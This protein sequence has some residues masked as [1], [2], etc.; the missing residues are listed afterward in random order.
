MFVCFAALAEVI[1]AHAQTPHAAGEALLSR[2][3]FSFERNAGQF[4]QG[5]VDWVAHRNGYHILLGASSATI[6]PAGVKMQFT[7][8]RAAAKS[9]AQE[10]LPGKVNYLIGNDP[11]RWIKDVETC[12]RVVYRDVYD[13]VDVAWYGSEG[14]I[15]YD[16][17]VRPGA[18]TSRIALHFEGARKLSLAANGDLRIDTGKDPLTLR[19]PTVYQETAGGRARVES[20]YVLRDDHTVAFAFALAP[21]DKSRPLVIDP[22]LMYAA[23]FPSQNVTVTSVATDPQGNI[24][25]G[26]SSDWL[27]TVSAFQPGSMGYEDPFV[28]KFDPTG[29]TVLY[30]TFVGGTGGD[31]L[32]GLAVDSGGYA[33]GVGLAYSKDFPTLNAAVPTFPSQTLSCGFAF[34]LNGDGDGLTYSTYIT[35]TTAYAVA[36]DSSSSAYVALYSGVQKYTTNGTIQYDSST[37]GGSAITVDAQGSAYVAGA[38]HLPA[39]QGVPGAREITGSQCEA[40]F[41]VY[42]TCTY[43]AKLSADGTSLNWAAILGG[44]LTQAPHAIARDPNSGEIYVAGETTATDLPVTGGVIQPTLHGQT[45]G[46]LASV[47]PDGSAF[48][49]VTYLGGAANDEIYALSLTPSGQIVVAGDTFS[50]DFPVIGAAQQSIGGNGTALYATTDSGSDWTTGGMNLP[51]DIT[52]LS[53]DPTNPS[54]VVAASSGVITDLA[55]LVNASGIYRSTDS[56]IMWTQVA[57]NGGFGNW[58]L[59]RS[60]VNP[61]VLYAFNATWSSSITSSDGGATWTSFGGFG[62]SYIVPSPTDSGTLLYVD[63]AGTIWKST[64]NG[65]GIV[66]V[67][68]GQSVVP[69]APT[70][71]PDG[72]IYMPISPYYSHPGGIVKSTDGGQT[73][74]LLV[75]SPITFNYPNPPVSVCAANPSVLFFANG[76]KLYRSSDAGATWTTLNFAASYVAVAPSNCQIVYAV[77]PHGLQVSTDG[78]NTWPPTPTTATIEQSFSAVAVDPTNAA[79]A[80]AVPGVLGG[81]AQ[82]GFAAKISTDG[83]NLLWSTFIGGDSYEDVRALTVNTSGNVWL[84]GSTGSSDLPVTSGVP[85][86]PGNGPYAGFLAEISDST[87]SCSF[88][89]SPQSAIPPA[90]GGTVQFGVV[91][92]SGCSWTATPSNNWISTAPSAGSTGSG[93]VDALIAPNGTG[94]TRTGSISVGDQ[95]FAVTQPAAS[96]QYALDRSSFLL[97]SSG[98]QAVVNVT[99]TSGCPWSVVPGGAKVVSGGGGTGSGSVTLSAPANAGLSPVAFTAQVANQAVAIKVAEN[100]TYSLSPLMIDGSLEFASSTITPNAPNCQWSAT[101]DVTWMRSVGRNGNNPDFFAMQMIPNTTGQART[102]HIFLGSQSFLMTQS[103]PANSGNNRSFVSSLGNDANNC[104]VTA[105]CQTLTRAL[106]MTNWGGEIVLLNSG[107]YGPATIAQPVTISA[108]GVAASITSTS[109]NALTINTPGDVTITGLG[110]HGHG[111][112]NDGVLVQEVGILRLYRVT[113]ENFAND[114]VEFATPGNIAIYDSRLTDNK[115]GLALLNSSAQAFVH[116]TSFDHNSLAGVYA[117]VGV[118]AIT[119]STAHFNDAGFESI[120]GTLVVGGSHAVSN[121]IGMSAIGVN[122]VMGFAYCSAVQ[123]S[124]YAYGASSSAAMSGT[125]SGTSPLGGATNGS[126]STP[127]PLE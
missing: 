105:P 107:E 122:A 2:I 124:L 54:V 55:E 30:A 64:Y 86:I 28:I 16:V 81:G 71:S 57:S 91:A 93:G 118:G 99:A 52:G 49:F 44:S 116:N 26:G 123:N 117:P 114:G 45:D 32:N 47:A 20:H 4:P 42:S 94:V 90:A 25:L 77:G 43:I 18:D 15:E 21:Y 112:G 59:V 9:E 92:P 80:L 69:L 40:N 101:S 119:N 96:C 24:Y 70:V 87:A 11:K 58:Q 82:N 108:V 33:V 88:Q 46:F 6:L 50:P 68:A 103:A 74:S 121:S 83:K 3:P 78:G 106:A 85:T 104:S 60:T 100:C 48:G 89:L 79:H 39:F 61:E 53:V 8:A 95:T 97:P 127:S 12:R 38:V 51:G 98:G 109:G 19:L 72:S 66:Q 102:G 75:G 65:T 113:A 63:G 34:R 27:P 37:A 13:G 115:Y 62:A 36:T 126:L 29:T 125:S 76:N 1:P 22:T 31:T 14:Q 73:W 67:S 10:P 23:V 35:D 84:A 17:I 41:T 7:G 56:G 111:T 120:G 110:L 5:D